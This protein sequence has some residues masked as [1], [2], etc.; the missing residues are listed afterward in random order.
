[1]SKNYLRRLPRSCLLTRGTREGLDG[2][3]QRGVPWIYGVIKRCRR[4]VVRV[5]T[6]LLSLLGAGDWGFNG[7]PWNGW[8]GFIP[9][10]QPSLEL[11]LSFCIW[12]GC[13]LFLSLLSFGCSPCLPFPLVVFL[14]VSAPFFICPPPHLSPFS[15]FFPLVLGIALDGL[16]FLFSFLRFPS[17]FP[18]FSVSGFGDGAIFDLQVKRV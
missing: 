9:F 7:C 14:H 10:F 16:W 6:P 8:L 15:S 13:V 17:L 11:V 18:F 1:M 4:R 12:S 2:L 3:E 5:E